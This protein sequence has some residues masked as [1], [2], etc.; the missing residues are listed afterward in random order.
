MP[1][2]FRMLPPLLPAV[3]AAPGHTAWCSCRRSEFF[4]LQFCGKKNP[5]RGVQEGLVRRLD[6]NFA[7]RLEVQTL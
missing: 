7:L 1:P 6:A 2:F 5:A 3:A 4:F